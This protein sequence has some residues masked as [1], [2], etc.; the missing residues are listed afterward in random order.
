VSDEEVGRLLGV[1]GRPVRQS[2]L[3]D[4]D[5]DDVGE[6]GHEIVID[7]TRLSGFDLPPAEGWQ[8]WMDAISGV[9]LVEGTN[10]IRI[11]RD[12]TTTD[13]FVVGVATVHWKEPVG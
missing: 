7:E 11:E 2:R 5:I 9:D 6:F 3:Q 10:T 1:D 8:L 13:S 12:T 4:V